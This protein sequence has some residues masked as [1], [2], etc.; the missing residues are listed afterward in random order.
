MDHRLASPQQAGSKLSVNA[1]ALIGRETDAQALTALLSDPAVSLVTV[2]GP[3]GVGKTSLASHVARTLTPAFRDGVCM[4]LLAPLRPDTP[5][6]TEVA[7]A[8]GLRDSTSR[9]VLPRVLSRL[10]RAHLL[11]L[12]DNA[13]HLPQTGPFV[14]ALLDVVENVRVLVTSRTPLGL[15]REQE[16]ALG[17]LPVPRLGGTF[18][19]VQTAASVQ[20]FQR[21]AKAVKRD[22][23]VRLDN[24]QAVAEI[25]AR[26]D[27]LPLAIELA[28]AR[29]RV[30]PPAMMLGH[31]HSTLELLTGGPGDRPERQR[32]LRATLEWSEQLLEP[33]QRR[34]LWTLGVFAQGA[35]LASISAVAGLPAHVALEQL[36]TLARHGLIRVMTGPDGDGRF[37]LLE[38]IREFALER[39][40]QQ[41]DGDSIHQRH[42]RHFL[43]F[44]VK[45]DA[46]LWGARQHE[47]L[48][49][50]EREHGNL[51]AALTWALQ[52]D[53]NLAL[54]LAAALGNFWSVHGHFA[55]GRQWLERALDGEEARSHAR[56][57]CAL[58][59][60]WR[61][62]RATMSRPSV[63]C[64]PVL[65]WP[66]IMLM[67][68][69]WPR[70]S[71]CWG[72]WHT[73]RPG[74]T[75]RGRF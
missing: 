4:V 48:S 50:L 47:V 5:A 29:V 37:D 15:S 72:S 19:E 10:E 22:F 61:G 55:E 23:E 38:I 16:F 25:C 67:L 3:G 49:A 54:D 8:L 7:R 2:T 40:V 59:V 60:R 6:E 42:A 14:S 9:D 56:G 33:E 71:T 65:P 24:A 39:L 27:G 46:D 35:S 62:C 45:A 41:G 66:V 68:V 13:E 36:E 11:L 51:R 21:R 73:T 75:R 28:A 69:G 30:L 17:A 64:P 20:L 32:S 53:Q 52:H 70:H 43:S 58:R 1:A 18:Q 12:L 34:L 31:L 44:A 74:P 26:L 63:C 57:P